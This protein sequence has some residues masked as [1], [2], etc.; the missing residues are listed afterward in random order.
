[1]STYDNNPPHHPSCL[2]G[3]NSHS[4]CVWQHSWD[5]EIKNNKWCCRP[6]I[7]CILTKSNP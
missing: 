4:S 7:S 1:M 2:Q 6:S 3:W 5:S